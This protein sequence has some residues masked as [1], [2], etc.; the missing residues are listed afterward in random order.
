MVSP[1]R[2]RHCLGSM[3]ARSERGGGTHQIP[4]LSQCLCGL[5]SLGWGLEVLAAWGS[6]CPKKATSPTQSPDEGEADVCV[7]AAL[8]C[9]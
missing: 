2:G 1:R 7:G 6:R 8:A 5:S 4:D 9:T 3:W